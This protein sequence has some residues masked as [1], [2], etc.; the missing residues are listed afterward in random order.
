MSYATFT[1]TDPVSVK[2][3][4]TKCCFKILHATEE[5][6]RKWKSICVFFSA[7]SVYCLLMIVNK[8][9]LIDKCVLR[10]CT[11]IDIDFDSMFSITE[12]LT[13]KFDSI[14]MF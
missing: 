4:H 6:K 13:L 7:N 3:S 2:L 10:V 8:K 1:K 11:D 5:V 14:S 12:K 9:T